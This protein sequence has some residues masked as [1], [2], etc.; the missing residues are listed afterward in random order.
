MPI[1]NWRTGFMGYKAQR[2][3][4]GRSSAIGKT[5]RRRKR[6]SSY[7]R[8]GRRLTPE[9]K[10]KTTIFSGVTVLLGSSALLNPLNL[11]T[12]GDTQSER[13]GMRFTIRS[14]ELSLSLRLAQNEGVIN[15]IIIRALLFV[16]TQAN[17][18]VPNDTDLLSQA[19]DV[20]ALYT[21]EER[22]RFKIYMD[23]KFTMVAP[24]LAWNS[25]N[26]TSSGMKK[27]LSFKKRLSLP[28]FYNAATSAV[29]GVT[30]NNLILWVFADAA[31]PA[32]T[33]TGSARIRYTDL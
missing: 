19:D 28:I 12:Q 14:V 29:T 32:V 1:W 24:G 10:V 22:H 3:G 9:L 18:A 17:G 2:P 26:E 23:R 25:V 20:N 11:I 6:P 8:I 4:Y 13:V 16:D 30:Q 27:L 5:Y 15:S 21:V 33:I 7:P 31:A